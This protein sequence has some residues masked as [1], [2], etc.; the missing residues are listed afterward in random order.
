MASPISDA[1]ALRIGLAART[2]PETDPARLIKVLA[3][4]VGLP[5]TVEKLATLRV[6]DLKSA[7]DGELAD[8]DQDALKAALAIL[9]GEGVAESDPPPPLDPYRDGDLPGSIRV[10]CASDTGELL[11]GHFGAAR[12]FLVYQV[13]ASEVRLIDVRRIDDSGA[14]DRNAYRAG[15][16]ADC[17]VLYVA[18]IGGPAAAKVIKLD[19]H[20]IKDAAG[21]SARERMVKLQDVLSRK[22]PPWLAKVMGQAPEERIRFEATA[23]LL[24][25]DRA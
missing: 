5:P 9:K 17:Q 14:E 8:I 24:D 4:A 11:D 7:A 23:D 20:P 21:G 25:G 13:S 18:S 2:L 22:A 1:I 6:K 15:L 12:R 3:S 16:I 19:I 10:A